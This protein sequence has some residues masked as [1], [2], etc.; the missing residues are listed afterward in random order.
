MKQLI[1]NEMVKL[2][3][4]KTYVVLSCL[5]LALVIIV[6]FFTSVLVT[7]LNNLIANRKSIFTKSAAYEWAVDTIKQDPDSALAGVLRTVFKNPKSE[8]D[9]LREQAQQEWEDGN[10]ASYAVSVSSAALMDFIEDNELEAWVVNEIQSDLGS[11][12]RWREVYTG[13]QNGTYTPAD[14]ADDYYILYMLVD[15]PYAEEYMW[16]DVYW[17]NDPITGETVVKYSYTSNETGLR[18]EC[19]LEDIMAKVSPYKLTCDQMIA[20]IEQYALTIEP[21]KYYDLLIS[22]KR[23]EIQENEALIAECKQKI[24]ELDP[25]SEYYQSNLAYL[26]INIEYYRGCNEDLERVI[27]AYGYLKEQERSPNGNSFTIVHKLLPEL[28]QSRRSAMRI[29][30]QSEID[31]GFVLLNKMSQSSYRHQIRVMDKALIAVEYAYMHDVLPEDMSPSDAKGTMISNLSIASFLISAVTIVLSSMIL[32][33]EFATGTIRLWVIRPKTRKKLLGSKIATLFIYV[34]TMMVASFFITGAFALVN[35]VIDLFFYGE[36]TLFTSNYGVVLGR[37]VAIPAFAELLWA[38]VILTLPVLLYAM[39]CFFISVLTK[40]GVLGIVCGMLVLMFATDIQAITLIVSNYTG[41]FGYAL[42]ATVL[43]YLGMDRLLVTSM[44]FGVATLMSGMLENIGDLMGIEN[45]L[46]S[47]Y[48]GAIPYVC[49]TFVGAAVLLFHIVLLV[50]ASLF[51]FKRT[52]I[53]S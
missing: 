41:V 37:T 38:L 9:K 23:T 19:T 34:G 28:L 11:L 52:Q 50:W 4:Q 20:E 3:A 49:S 15:F 7:P 43:P 51:A 12:Y 5:V 6:S 10:K 42:Q 44:D 40:K 21:D 29:L 30:D 17:E 2:R 47:Q 33:R 22:Q 1:K 24:T 36:S 39:I 18:V 27:A 8:S 31:D 13:V 53:K 45:M 35:H 14:M 16:Y 32:S 48:W 46:M 26:E 25:E